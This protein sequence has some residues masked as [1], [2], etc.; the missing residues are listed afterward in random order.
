MSSKKAKDVLSA[1][2]AA[3]RHKELAKDLV[4]FRVSLDPSTISSGKGPVQLRRELR[5]LARTAV[6]SQKK[7]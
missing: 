7:K 1:A 4:K 2:D 5:A 3:A 6:S